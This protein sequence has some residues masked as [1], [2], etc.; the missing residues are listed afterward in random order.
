M[1]SVTAN[2]TNNTSV[3]FTASANAPS[4][5]LTPTISNS[6]I[7]AGSTVSNVFV[8][9]SDGAGV[10]GSVE[11][12]G[13]GVTFILFYDNPVVG[14]NSGSVNPPSGYGGSCAVGGGTNAVFNYTLNVG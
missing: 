7:P 5:G 9:N 10:E 14:S 3:S 11:L 12:S 13:G 8:A 6:T 1:T 2:V 4:H